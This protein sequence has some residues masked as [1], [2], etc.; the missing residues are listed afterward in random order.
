LIKDIK[1]KVLG[2]VVARGGSKGIP[3]KNLKKTEKHCYP[4]LLDELNIKI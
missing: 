1:V 4:R 3:R 2:V